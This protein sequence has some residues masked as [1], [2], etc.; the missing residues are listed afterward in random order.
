MKGY[1]YNVTVSADASAARDVSY[2]IQHK[3]FPLW[4]EREGWQSARLLVIPTPKE[5]GCSLAMQ[6]EL[7]SLDLL[8]DFCLEEDALVQRVQEVY[9]DK[10]LFYPTLMEVIG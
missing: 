7:A 2:Y 5:D 6:F 1:I 10:V 9:G 3:L 4:Q 8:Q